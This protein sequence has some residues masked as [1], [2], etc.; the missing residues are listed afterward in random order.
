M[1]HNLAYYLWSAITEI[2]QDKRGATAMIVAVAAPVLI[3]FAALGAETGTWFTIKLRNQS[4]AD[5]A[6]ISAAYEVLAG[7]TDLASDLMPAAS[8]AA[9]R[10]GYAGAWPA[11]IYPYSDNIVSNGV[12]VTLQE[13]KGTLLASMFLSSVKI[14]TT[15]VAVIE[16]LDNP[17]VLALGTSGMDVEVS[18]SSRLDMPDCSV[19]ANSIS[20]TAIDLH[21]ST[22]SI[23]AATLVT[24]GEVSF[25]GNPIDPAAPPPEFSLTSSP[26]I[27]APGILDPYA[28]RLTHA[29]L[30]SSISVTNV[31]R[32]FWNETAT[33]QPALYENGISFGARAVINMTPGVYYITNGNFAVAS[34]ATVSCMSCSG[35]NGVT[36]ILTT[37]AATGAT[38]GNVLISPGATVTLSA[39][40][41]GLFSGLLF[42]QDPLAVSGGGSTPDNTLEG[43]TGMKLGGLLY[44][45]RTTVRFAGNPSA[46]CTLLIA[47]QLTVE[48]VS[49]LT[50]AGCKSAGLT[51]LPTVNTVAL[52]E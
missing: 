25:Q 5:A 12:A 29:F 38:I 9:V 47:N 1:W 11:V 15:A 27:G 33:I 21:G 19:A 45:P 49:H 31:T 8:E 44:F 20:S 52:A 10:N 28:G 41:S 40:N 50:V 22:S 4:A 34:G 18:D 43:G 48:G 35:S 32:Q 7:K 39:P 36:V 30:T 6:A 17:C 2:S 13:A 23:A 46:A 16:V 3:G 51:N 24:Q 26:M 42:V 14:T 37:T